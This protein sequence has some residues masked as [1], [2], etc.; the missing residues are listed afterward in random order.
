MVETRVERD[1]AL[2]VV[3]GGVAVAAHH[4]HALEGDA[5]GGL[6]DERETEGGESRLARSSVARSRDAVL[7]GVVSIG[8]SL[9]LLQGAEGAAT[10]AR[11]G[12]P[13]GPFGAGCH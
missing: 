12:S 13:L 7:K 3:L 4:P 9:R 2:H 11:I 5:P 10:C 8:A 6:G 1:E